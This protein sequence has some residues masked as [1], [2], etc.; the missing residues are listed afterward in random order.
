MPISD[1]NLIQGTIGNLYRIPDF[2]IGNYTF[3]QILDYL[4]G[5]GQDQNWNIVKLILVAVSVLLGILTA[6]VVIKT[7]RLTGIK[8]NLVK[9]LLPPQPATSGLNARWDEIERHINSTREAEWK[10][11]VIEADK[12]VD[13][14]L[15][16]AGFPGDTMGDRL[17]NIQPGQ[18][19]TLQNL[20]EAHKI[21]NRLVHDVNYFLR[22][23]EAKRAVGLYE[24]TLKELQAL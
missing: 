17:M 23:T 15:K 5:F 3:A 18:L 22:Y 2:K 6:I 8:V 9:E 19:T 1:N 14:L 16:G 11:A 4:P 20:W 24:K 7:N 13:E 21:R 10:F 12:L